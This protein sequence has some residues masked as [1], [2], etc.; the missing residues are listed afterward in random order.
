MNAARSLKEYYRRFTWLLLW[1]LSLQ[2]KLPV[3]HYRLLVASAFSISNFFPN[4]YNLDC[5]LFWL[6]THWIKPGEICEG[7]LSGTAHLFSLMPTWVHWA[8]FL[9][10]VWKHNILFSHCFSS[11]ASRL[12]LYPSLGASSDHCCPEALLWNCFFVVGVIC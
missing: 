11:N 5:L 7:R 10:W 6:K 3:S 8:V 2:L 12:N 1:N 4:I 9:L